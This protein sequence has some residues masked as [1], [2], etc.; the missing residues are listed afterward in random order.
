MVIRPETREV[1]QS[2][3]LSQTS[4]NTFYE[5]RQQF[6][7]VYVDS[8]IQVDEKGKPFAPFPYDW[9][10]R[11][12]HRILEEFYK[13]ENFPSQEELEADAKNKIEAVLLNLLDKHWEYGQPDYHLKDAKSMLQLFA[14]RESKRWRKSQKDASINF[15]PFTEVDL[16]DIKHLRLRAIIDAF[17]LDQNKELRPYPR[18]YKTSKEAKLTSQMK[19]QALVCSM[20]LFNKLGKMPEKFEFLFLRTNKS[21]TY[22]ITQERINKA[23]DKIEFMWREIKTEHFPKNLKECFWCPMKIFCAGMSRCWV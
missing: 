22:E 11:I 13:P 19:L 18:D 14:V 4:I 5:C 1:L 6:K 16:H 10:G 12:I 17:W 2:R 20:L 7:L 23:I 3:L 8:K 9:L 15:I 21:I